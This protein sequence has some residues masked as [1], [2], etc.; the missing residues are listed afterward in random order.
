MLSSCAS[1]SL[2]LNAAHLVASYLCRPEQFRAST[3]V[4]FIEHRRQVGSC[5]SEDLLGPAI[6]LGG[7]ITGMALP[8]CRTDC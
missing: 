8:V 2:P 7:M 5:S 3:T 6:G 1:I 4:R